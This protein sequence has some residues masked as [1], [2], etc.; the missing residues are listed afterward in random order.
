MLSHRSRPLYPHL[1]IEFN[2]TNL[3][4]ADYYFLTNLA[5]PTQQL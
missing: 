2:L 1:L 3:P 4:T 5:V